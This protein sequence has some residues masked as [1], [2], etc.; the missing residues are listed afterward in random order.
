MCVC[1]ALGL[2]RTLDQWVSAERPRTFPCESQNW[3][4]QQ[5]NGWASTWAHHSIGVL[6]AL[7]KRIFSREHRRSKWATCQNRKQTK[8]NDNRQHGQRN[9]TI[10]YGRKNDISADVASDV[11]IIGSFGKR[12][13]RHLVSATGGTRS[14]AGHTRTLRNSRMPKCKMARCFGQFARGR[15]PRCASATS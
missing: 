10:S 5:A 4:S 8:K 6:F 7:G 3:R 12:I 11:S 13:V 2:C 14:N 1:V 9:R 15:W